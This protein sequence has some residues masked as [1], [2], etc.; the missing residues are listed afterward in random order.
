MGWLEMIFGALIDDLKQKGEDKLAREVVE[1][2]S[3]VILEEYHMSRN[4]GMPED[5]AVLRAC[6]RMITHAL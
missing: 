1:D 5:E 2:H 3:E 4:H 6:R